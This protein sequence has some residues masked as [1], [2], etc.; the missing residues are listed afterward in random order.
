MPRR[1]TLKHMNRIRSM[2]LN[3]IS[4]AMA[5]GVWQSLPLCAQPK[6]AASTVESRTITVRIDRPFDQVY[7]FLVDPV[8]WN[9]W[10]FG[11]GQNLRHSSSGWVA[12]SGAG[13]G[14]V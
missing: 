8:N 7:G 2:I 9:Q 4:F 13:P 14:H 5:C 6:T 1:Y 10:A 11:L 3:G 12:D